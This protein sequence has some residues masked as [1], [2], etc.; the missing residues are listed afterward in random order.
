MLD[1][2]Q[3]A[4]VHGM[5]VVTTISVVVAVGVAILAIIALR[6][7]RSG[8]NDELGTPSTTD[9]DDGRDAVRAASTLAPEA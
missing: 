9:D 6:D 1:A 7:V 4:F 3:A 8:D 2:A 5:Q